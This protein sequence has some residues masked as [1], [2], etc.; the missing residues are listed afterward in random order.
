MQA[1]TRMMGIVQRR[2]S[3]DAQARAGFTPDHRHTG[4]GPQTYCGEDVLKN[5]QW[6]YGKPGP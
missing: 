3:G 4:E 2:M 1:G 6:F 5:G